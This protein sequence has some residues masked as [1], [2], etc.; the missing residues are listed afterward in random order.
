MG[1]KY[2][3]FE[4]L[5]NTDKLYDLYICALGFE[6]RSLGSNNKILKS[7]IQA[8]YSI[9]L[10]YTT[11]KKD[12]EE[13]KSDFE[14]IIGKISNDFCYI[15]YDFSK[16]NQFGERLVNILHKKHISGNSAII[17]ITS[18][19]THALLWILNYLLDNFNEIKI[20]YT[21]P[22]RYNLQ[23]ENDRSFAAGVKDIF[24]IPE[25]IG[26]N[27]PGYMTLLVILLGYDLIRARGVMTQIQPSKKIGIIPKPTTPNMNNE[28]QKNNAAHS[29]SFSHNDKLIK[30]TIFDLK[31][32][33]KSLID[34]RLD[35]VE[36]YNILLAL[37][38]SKL[39]AVAALLFAKKF[40]DI[41]LIL[42]T[43]LEYFP[44]SY[45]EGTGDTYTITITKDWLIRFL[46]EKSH[47]FTQRLDPI[48]KQ[49]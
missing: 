47:I 19:T 21:S 31:S 41:Q 4:K 29:I 7:G 43:P 12:N 37:N 36:N 16:R 1:F 2:P 13:N 17:N 44:K 22:K 24:T 11:N 42:S 6:D 35:H 33:I 18:F 23:S 34:V 20:V 27:L 28:F 8:K 38:G 9:I 15:K 40:H 26:A 14:R 3:K 48:D 5:S 49:N 45:S 46:H 25:F 32:L 10:Q 30:L 39:H